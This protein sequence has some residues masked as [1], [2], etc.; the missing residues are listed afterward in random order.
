MMLVNAAG[1]MLARLMV[2]DEGNFQVGAS[3][4]TRAP[5]NI[6]VFLPVQVRVRIISAVYQWMHEVCVCLCV[7]AG[8]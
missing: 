2:I 3:D 5:E 8:V 4:T 6:T 1:M 7:R